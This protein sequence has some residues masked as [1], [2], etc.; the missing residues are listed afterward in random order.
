MSIE[1]IVAYGN[2]TFGP[3]LQACQKPPPLLNLFA[4]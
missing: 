4:P 3:I 2:Q 1:G